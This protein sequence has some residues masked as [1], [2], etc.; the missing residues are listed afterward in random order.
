MKKHLFLI[1]LLVLLG[2]GA[3][4]GLGL[5]TQARAQERDASVVASACTVSYDKTAAPTEVDAG[6]VT[7]I[8]FSLHAVGDCSSTNSPVDVMLVID[9]SGSMGGQRIADAKQAAIGFINQMDLTVD[10]VGVASFAT[11]GYG[12]LDHPLSQDA[13]SVIQEIND[14]YASGMTDIKEGLEIAA[15]EIITSGRHLATNA[16]VILIL[17]DGHHNETSAGEL[18]DTA[19]LIKGEGIRIISIGLGSSADENQL[20]AI[21]SSEDDYYYA[22]DSADL[23]DIYRS[24][25]GSVRVAARDMVITD[26]LSSYVSLVPASFQG[27][28]S[29]TV[30]GDQIV[31]HVAAVSTNTLSLAYQVVMTDTPNTNPGWPTHDSAG[32]TYIDAGGNPAS[33]TFPTPYVKVRDQC[34][35]PTLNSI[36]PDWACVNTDVPVTLVGGGFVD[37]SASIGEQALTIHCAS[38][39]AIIATLPAG[40]EAGIHDVSVVNQCALTATLPAAFT[41]YSQPSILAIRPLE[42]YQDVPTELTICG[43]GFAPGTIAYIEVTTGTIALENQATFGENC[44]VGTVPK[45]VEEGEHTIIVESPCGTATGSYRVLAPA[46]NDDLWG[47]GEELWV[48]PSVCA[49]EDDDINIGLIVHRRGGKETLQNVTVRFY[50]GNP[51]EPGAVQIG[52]GTIYQLSPRVGPSERISGTST[53][54]VAWTPSQGIG[55]YLLYA[56][57]DPHDTVVEDIEDNNVVSRTVRVLPGGGGIDGVAPHVDAFSINGETD[58]VYG[59]DVSLQVEATDFA[60]GGV[61]PSGVA[62]MYFVE[63][64][65]NESAGVWVPVGASGWLSFANSSTW[66][67]VPQGGLRYLQAWASD[68]EANISRYPY[69][70]QINYIRPCDYVSRD[71]ARSYRQS[72]AQGDI[73]YVEVVPCQGD[74]DLYIWPPDWDEGRPPWVSNLYAG[75]EVLSITAPISGVYQIEVYGYTTARYNIQIESQ[76]ASSVLA[77][78]ATEATFQTAGVTDKVTRTAPALPPASVPQTIMGVPPAPATSHGHQIYLPLVIRGH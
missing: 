9:R 59:Q 31:W 6:G 43:E 40:L 65:F 61:I 74:P 45:G 41:L 28:I 69:Q 78:M 17:S 30:S 63:F 49:R 75:T 53:S 57:I 36:W 47:R 55:E 12:T 5:A 46:L 52:D 71:G 3:V 66:S 42:G 19:N 39:R 16:P 4:L 13:N 58:V 54:A 38:Q 24:I 67:L 51:G 48:D 27:P 21:A 15:T 8:T 11:T 68:A 62:S 22:P 20:R 34:G 50:E 10:Q 76:L 44:L 18:L 26:T 73:L 60:Q 7:T 29:P 56:V 32:A 35:Q 14:L 64:L 72:L 77:L 37:P 33:I 1:V 70:R 25:A 23:M 2:L